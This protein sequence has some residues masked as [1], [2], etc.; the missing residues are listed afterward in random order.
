MKKRILVMY[1]SY[2]SGHKAIA[3]YVADYVKSQDKELEVA[4]L[5]ILTYSMNV[6]GSISQKI[7]SFFM[8]KT[9]HIHNLFYNISSTKV[10]G[11][12][13]DDLSLTIFKNRKM[14]NKI[15]NFN[16][17]LVVATHFF[18]AGLIN[19]YNKKGVTNAKVINVITDYDVIELWIKYHQK[20]DYIV[21]GNSQM[22]KDLIKRKVDK[23]KIKPFG[24]PIAPK[25]SL[26][27]NLKNLLK[28][29]NLTGDRPICLFFGGGG[30]GSSKTLPY[31]KKIAIS[32]P[33]LD[34]IFIAGKNEY[35]KNKVDSFVNEKHLNNVR[36]IGFA[37]NVPELLELAD[38]VISKPGGI[39]LTECLYFKKPVLMIRHSGGQEIANYKFFESVGYGKYF[40]TSW[41]L[42][43]YVKNVLVDKSILKNYKI[44]MIQTDNSKAMENLYDLI[45]SVLVK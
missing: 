30:N 4:T 22:K 21:V 9:P 28:Q 32:N 27:F 40:R 1:A 12:V 41:G 6:I 44:N 36:T 11:D 19:Y 43:R 45:K 2:G 42:N 15:K 7:N 23:N 3:N 20:I 31:I 18:G 29:F 16:P 5:D 13:I 24:I 14:E 17:D 25:I 33:N 26:N 8:L 38:F 34:I 39:Q 10:G 35:S 37:S